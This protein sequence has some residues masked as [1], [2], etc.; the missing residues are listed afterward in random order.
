MVMH[1][2]INGIMDCRIYKWWNIWMIAIHRVYLHSGRIL[3]HVSVLPALAS[4][5]LYLIAHMVRSPLLSCCLELLEMVGWSW[6]LILQMRADVH[7]MLTVLLFQCTK[8]AL[9]VNS[10]V[11]SGKGWRWMFTSALSKDS[12]ESAQAFSLHLTSSGIW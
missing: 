5:L 10:I 7:A 3:S 9:W 11:V 12:G 8:A 4:N 6:L 1:L 2:R